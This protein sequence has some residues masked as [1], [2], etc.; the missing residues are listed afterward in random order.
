MSKLVDPDDLSYV[1][2][3]T[4][5]G[6]DEIEIQTGAKTIKLLPQGTLSDDSPGATSGVTGKCLYSKFKEIWKSDSDLNK[7]RFPIQMIYEASFVWINGWGPEGDQTRDLFRDAGFKEVDGR[8][9]ACMISLGSMDASTDQGY[10]TN[11]AGLDQTKV[12]LDKTGEINENIQTKGTGGTPDNSGYAKLFLREMQK[13]FAE[14]DLLAE[15]GLAALKYEAY[16]MPLANAPDTLKAIDNDTVIGT[17]DAGSLSGVKYSELTIDY[18]AGQLYETAAAQSYSVDDVLQ[19]GAGRWYRC[20]TA[21]TVDATDANDLGTMGGSGS[22]VFEVFPGERQIGADYYAFNRIL[23]VQ[24]VTNGYSARLKEIHSWAQYKCRQASDIND[25]VNGD[26]W[27]TVYGNIAPVFTGFVGDTLHTAHG[28]FVDNYDVNDKNDLIMWDITVD[29]GGVDSTTIL[30]ATSTGRSFPFTAA[31][32]INFSSNFVDEVDSTTRYTM[33]FAHITSTAVTGMKVSGS[34]GAGATLDWT[35]DAGALDHL[36]NGDYLAITGFTTET[37]N[38]GLWEITG[39]PS[40][41][42]VTASKVDGIDP[43]DEATGDTATC[44]QNPFESPGAVIVDN[45]AGTD[46][47]GEISAASIGF[48]FDY[49]NNNQ[50]GRAADTNADVILVAIAYD[51]AQYTVVNHTIT[52]TTGQAVAVNAVDELNYENA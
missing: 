43:V 9:N 5:G 25:D 28:V 45:N 17:T 3:T 32:N 21:G 48:D 51:G 44:K 30:P 49:T 24:D 50:G 23:D 4:A 29:G 18:I 8:E 41:N 31:G 37:D 12:N 47:D 11:V 19:D 27:G 39:S 26:A 6:S 7:H 35:G 40:S 1:V 46:I 10:Y 34:S 16:R 14:Y 15:Q 13:T 2:D 38:N 42:T 52:K 33:Y 20:T 36:S 22:A